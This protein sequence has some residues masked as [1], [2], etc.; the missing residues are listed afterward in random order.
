LHDIAL[1]LGPE[2]KLPTMAELRDELEVSTYTLNAAIRE[3]ER[4]QVLRSVNGVGIYV[5][6]RKKMLTGNIGILGSA[7]FHQPQMDY[8]NLFMRG[9]EKAAMLNK[10]HFLF[11]GTEKTWDV[12]SCEKVDGIIIAGA[13]QVE[14]VI[15]QIPAALP[16]V[17][18]LTATKNTPSVTVDDYQGAKLAVQYLHQK[19]HRR[20]ACLMEELPVLSRR[21]FAGY[22]DALLEESIHAKPEWIRLT[23]SVDVTKEDRPY[24]TWGREQMKSW[25]HQGWR[26]TG[27]TAIFVQNET[28]AIGVMQILQ[29]E[30]IKVPE[31]VSIIG[32]DGTQLCDYVSPRLCAVEIPLAD[33]GAKSMELLNQQIINNEARPSSMVLPLRIREGASVAPLP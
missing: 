8:Y 13:N 32:F 25:L 18:A 17:T 23:S 20:I 5:T 16:I 12:R 11:L 6:R 31:Q 19:K 10:Q 33:I 26:E 2:A 1:E 28:A 7:S 14:P 22:Q 29:E 27:C 4:R 24:L 30:N 9:M 21:R 15:R 3:L